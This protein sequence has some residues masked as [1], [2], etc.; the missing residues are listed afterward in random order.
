[1][2]YIWRILSVITLLPIGAIVIMFGLEPDKGQSPS[3]TTSVI[4]YGIGAALFVATGVIWL[5]SMKKRVIMDAG[6]I[7]EKTMF[8]EKRIQFG[9]GTTIAHESINVRVGTRFVGEIGT[10]GVLLDNIFSSL[11]EDLS[12]H[13]N[14]TI[15]NGEHKIKLNS[16]IKG[17]SELKNKIILA[18][19]QFILPDIKAK[20]DDNMMVSF[21]PISIR[22]NDKLY[23][24]KKSVP[25][26]ELAPPVL[27]GRELAIIPA[28]ANLVLRAGDGKK[29]FARVN[30]G[31]VQ[32]M[33][34][35]LAI[36]EPGIATRKMNSPVRPL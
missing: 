31:K 2:T 28:S 25:L 14:I 8:G 4:L 16:N 20:Y 13:I 9:P 36:L 22:R 27:E 30:A 26:S 18:E 6:H 24:W 3:G 23:V 32:N 10:S 7:S 21:G 5:H 35:L 29:V 12:T 33:Y 11:G 34:S 15:K 1:M 17:I 19:M